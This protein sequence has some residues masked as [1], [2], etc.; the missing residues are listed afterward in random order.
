MIDSKYKIEDRD[1]FLKLANE[2]ADAIDMS[3]TIAREIFWEEYEELE[4]AIVND[5][6]SEIID[7]AFDT[8]FTAANYR[9]ENPA[10]FYRRWE[11]AEEICEQHGYDWLTVCSIGM[12]SNYS[13]LLVLDINGDAEE[14][15]T[16]TEAFVDGFHKK[17]GEE[18][19]IT[20][21]KSTDGM[22]Y[23]FC[24]ASR[25]FEMDGK[26][27]FAGKLLKPASFVTPV[28]EKAKR[29]HGNNPDEVQLMEVPHAV[30]AE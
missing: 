7:G 11:D 25:E 18:N 9:R 24:I 23:V 5:D 14:N 4:L 13:K 16:A 21:M 17:Y 12:E 3:K 15:V 10:L 29:L 30:S 19:V 2:W 22:I 27:F 28:W 20:K 1:Q 26:R 8:A 6:E